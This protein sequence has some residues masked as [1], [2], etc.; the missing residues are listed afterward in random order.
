MAKNNLDSFK[1]FMLSEYSNIAQAHFKSIET[2]S[3]FFRY[4]LL[5]MTIP[6][7]AIGILS[8]IGSHNDQLIKLIEDFKT[9]ISIILFFISLIGLGVFCY[10]IN[11]RLD[12]ILYARTV[13]GIRKYFYDIFDE[14]INLKSRWRVLPQSPQLP[15][16]FEISYFIPVVFVFSIMNSLYALLGAIILTD[17]IKRPWALIL[18]LAYFLSHLFIYWMYGRHRETAYLKSNIIGI[19]IDGVLN[20][21]REH[22]CKIL[23]KNKNIE[24]SPEQ[25]VVIPVHECPSL[26][27]TRD[28]EREVFNDPEYWIKMPVIEN[29]A[30]IIRSLKNIF[31]YNIFI[32]TYRP[33]PDVPDSEGKQKLIEKVKLFCSNSNGFTLRLL[34]LKIGTR[35]KIYWLIRRF[36]EEPLKLITKEWLH[37]LLNKNK[38][39]YKLFFE[40]GNDFSSDPRGNFNNRFYIS[41]KRKIRFFVEDDISKAIKLS[42]I[43]DVVLLIS[44]PYNEPH[45]SLPF[46]INNNLRKNLPSNIIRVKDWQE[47]YHYLKILS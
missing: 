19:D 39:K 16:Y 14:D 21:H 35:L 3:T 18:I 36:K 5:I 27:V 33:W 23:K 45:E 29:A 37:N 1:N 30:E 34:L 11:L 41:R 42:Y 4:Y 40:K 20:K 31:K 15:F 24:I 17:I 6:L 12:A 46:H 38:I 22:F 32:F 26:N 10:I 7:S 8:Q 25:I 47:I 9:P 43:C 2:I 28:I 13:N 44:H